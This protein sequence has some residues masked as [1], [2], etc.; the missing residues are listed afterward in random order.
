MVNPNDTIGTIKAYIQEERGISFKKQRILS[1][2][3]EDL[4]DVQK[5]RDSSLIL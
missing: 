3:G 4:S 1:K 5:H 2:N